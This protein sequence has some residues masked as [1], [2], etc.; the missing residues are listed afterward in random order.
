MELKEAQMRAEIIQA[1]LAP[2]CSRIEIAGSIRRKKPFCRD[3]DIVL[4]PSNQGQILAVLTSFGK[5]KSGAG[6]LINLVTETGQSVDIYIADNWTW[7]TLLLIRT[8]S[9]QHNIKLCS[10]AKQKGMMLHA[11]GGGLTRPTR[12]I[13]EEERIAWES[14][15]SI[16]EALGIPYKTPEER[17]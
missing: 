9:K 1:A 17:E 10:L 2:Y 15:E 11:D 12:A 16:F 14:E 5:I 7:A 6:K 8:G 3:I 13:G 4:I